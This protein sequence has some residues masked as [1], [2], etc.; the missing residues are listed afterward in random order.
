LTA[1]TAGAGG[2]GDLD[3]RAAGELDLAEL[4]EQ[5]E[6]LEYS[7]L[8]STKLLRRWES[9][10]QGTNPASSAAIGRLGASFGE[11]HIG[12]ARLRF[13]D[14]LSHGNQGRIS[15]VPGRNHA[16]KLR[17]LLSNSPFRF[18]CPGEYASDGGNFDLRVESTGGVKG[19]IAASSS[20]HRI[21]EDPGIVR[22]AVRYQAHSEEKGDRKFTGNLDL[23][24]VN[25]DQN[26][27]GNHLRELSGRS[28]LR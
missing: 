6:T 25:L 11:S 3:I 9:G 20:W 7:R 12:H 14:N 18:S 13:D 1:P 22:G 10:R 8:K 26:P 19:G 16:E 21:P 17:A 28:D 2:Q 4:C 24:G 5:N 15:V 27:F 23:F